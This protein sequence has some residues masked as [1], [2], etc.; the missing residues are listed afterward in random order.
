MSREIESILKY[1]E[2]KDTIE[3]AAD[4]RARALERCSIVRSSRANGVRSI[5]LAGARADDGRRSAVPLGR[6]LQDGE[7][8]ARDDAGRH[9]RCLSRRLAAG[10]EGHWRFIAMARRRASRC[11]HKQRRR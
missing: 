3:G 9:R 6:D 11:Q 10:A 8:A 4:L 1:I 7:H 2:A 5:S